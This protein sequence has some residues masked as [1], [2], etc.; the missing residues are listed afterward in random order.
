[1][2]LLFAE[3]GTDVV[4]YDPSE[5]NV[6]ALMHKAKDTG[7]NTKIT[8]ERDYEAL[9]RALPSPKVFFFSL[10]HGSIGDKTV[11]SLK[12]FLKAGDVILDASNEH[13]ERTERRQKIC[14]P[15]GVHF[16]GSGVS[17]GYQ[18]A[19]HGPSMSPGGNKEAVEK[20]LPFLQKAAAKDAEGRPCVAWMGEG[21]S[22]HYVKMVHNGIEQ[23]MMSVLCEVWGIMNKSLGMGYEEIGNVFTDWDSSGELVRNRFQCISPPPYKAPLSNPRSHIQLRNFLVSIGADICHTKDPK[24]PN[25]DSYVLAQVKD[26]VVQDVDETEGTGTWTLEEASRLHVSIPTIAAAHLFRLAS[27]DAAQRAHIH[28]S[29][30]GHIQVQKIAVPNKAAFLEDLRKATYA[31]FLMAFV[32]GLDLLAHVDKEKH[33]NLDFGHIIQIWRG[34][35]IIQSDYI[36]DLLGRVYKHHKHLHGNLLTAHEV[37][38]E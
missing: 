16:I 20:M 12:P 17:G 37:G 24:S 21:G 18:S 14:E 13:Y 32:Q 26:K 22:G 29:L 19:R 34:G 36:S 3:L 9:C 2:S 27:A 5:A 38:H 33:W 31:S 6:K 7:L 23:G 8:S 10:P 28:T 15:L 4:V 35:C 25:G 11:E 30:A 1:M